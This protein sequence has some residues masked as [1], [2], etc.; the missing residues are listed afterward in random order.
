MSAN[1]A[2]EPFEAPAVKV[3]REKVAKERLHI[4]ITEDSIQ[5]VDE[6]AHELGLD[7][8]PCIQV[9]I[10]YALNN[11]PKIPKGAQLIHLLSQPSATGHRPSNGVAK[12]GPAR[13]KKKKKKH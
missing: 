9:L 13:V 4:Y 5:R 10:N 2:K 8:S 7:R 3:K 1:D 12:P 11:F 6:K